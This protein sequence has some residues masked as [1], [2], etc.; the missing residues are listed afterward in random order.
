MVKN[1]KNKKKSKFDVYTIYYIVYFIILLIMFYEFFLF[2]SYISEYYPEIKFISLKSFISIGEYTKLSKNFVFGLRYDI[3]IDALGI[4]I[5]ILF[6]I[7]GTQSA[8]KTLLIPSGNRVELPE[9]KRINF[10]YI[11]ASWIFI[12]LVSTYFSSLTMEF[13][14]FEFYSD[15]FYYVLGSMIIAYVYSRKISKT[16]ESFS[17]KKENN[18]NQDCTEINK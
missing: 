18:N 11:I 17:I 16:T 3:L 13:K 8:F 12:T 15:K 10:L 5:F 9:N 7:E 6:G 4:Y 1:N 2:C 14:T